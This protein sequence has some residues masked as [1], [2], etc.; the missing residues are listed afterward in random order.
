MWLQYNFSTASCP[1]CAPDSR[2]PIDAQ[3]VHLCYKRRPLQRFLCSSASHFAVVLSTAARL[4]HFSH[5]KSPIYPCLAAR[6]LQIHHTAHHHSPLL[7]LGVLRAND[8]HIAPL[9]PAHALA[10]VTQLLDRAAHLHASCL[11]AELAQN[12]TLGS[13]RYS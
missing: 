8:V 13:R 3:Y 4:L 6:Q 1:S 10:S 5:R 11:L 7:V 9:L 2:T 12:A